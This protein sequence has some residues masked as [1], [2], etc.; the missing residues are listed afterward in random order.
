MMQNERN[1][2]ANHRSLMY[3]AALQLFRG[4]LYRG[5]GY[6]QPKVQTEV[7]VQFIEFHA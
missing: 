6:D 5:F 4:I 7:Q 3:G 1:I 2:S